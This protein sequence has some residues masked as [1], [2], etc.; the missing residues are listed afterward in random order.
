MTSRPNILMLFP[1]QWRADW[2]GMFVTLPL[3]TPNID[4][5]AARGV[6]FGRAW[7]P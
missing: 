2:L 7:T 5:I 1:D 4:A 3:R 6:S